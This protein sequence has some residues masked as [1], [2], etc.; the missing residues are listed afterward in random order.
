MEG[1]FSATN[2]PPTYGPEKKPI[3]LALPYIGVHSDKVKRQLLR[4]LGAVAPWIKPIIVFKPSVKLSLLSK[5]KCQYPLLSQSNI[6]YKVECQQCDEFYIGKTIR[7]LHQR[8]KEH[9]EDECSAL[10]KH[11]MDKQHI[12][13]FESPTILAR[14]GHK[15]RLLVK[16]SLLIM[17]QKAYASLNGNVGS[18]PL[19]LW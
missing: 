3:F 12:I 14:D 8:L 1:T 11:A 4:T 6:V 18:T 5:L 15:F 16:E 9:S 7:R 17:Q 19:Y 10:F 13:N 2:N